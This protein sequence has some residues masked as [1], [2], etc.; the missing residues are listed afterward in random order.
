MGLLADVCESQ[1]CMTEAIADLCSPSQLRTLLA[2]LIGDGAPARVLF[3]EHLNFLTKD[4]ILNQGLSAAFATNQLLFDLQRR[5]EPMGKT[6]EGVGLPV[7][8]MLDTEA[9]RQRALY[10]PTVCQQQ[11]EDNYSKVNDEQMKFIQIVK[12]LLAQQNGGLLFLN[13][14]AGKIQYNASRI[15]PI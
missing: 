11:Y 7:P 15:Y 4:Y 12:N 10:D 2:S 3:D 1:I 14:A 13:G 6:L 9:A 5:L 8:E